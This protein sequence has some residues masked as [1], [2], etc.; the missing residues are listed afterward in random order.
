LKMHS[1]RRNRRMT[2]LEPANVKWTF[3]S[4]KVSMSAARLL[5]TH[6]GTANARLKIPRVCGT[7]VYLK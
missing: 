1:L 6:D 7:L 3:F 4:V 2:R 5:K